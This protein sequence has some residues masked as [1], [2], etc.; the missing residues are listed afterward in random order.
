M[1]HSREAR[2]FD[3]GLCGQLSQAHPLI[4]SR[5]VKDV[6]EL[7]LG[8][9]ASLVSALPFVNTLKDTHP[10]ASPS[11]RESCIAGYNPTL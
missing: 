5:L 3:P 6:A 7:R 11:H 9:T 1:L 10:L 8:H 4:Q 2:E